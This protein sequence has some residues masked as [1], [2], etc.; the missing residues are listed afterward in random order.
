VKKLVGCLILAAATAASAFAAPKTGADDQRL[1]QIWRHV[2]NRMTDQDDIWFGLGDY[3]AC[4]NLLRYMNSESP[5]D[6]EYAT[7]LGWML[8]NVE[9]Y[10]QAL[11]V[12]VR[13]RKDNTGMPDAPF[14]EANF[15]FSRKAYAKVPPLLE[16]SIVQKPHPNSYRLLAHSYEKLG[17]LPDALKVW[18]Q[19]VSDHP[20]DGAA[21]VNL[22]KTEDRISSQKASR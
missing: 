4:I 5:T 9:N 11:V 17:L 20:E 22:K 7:N 14:P 3:L 12:Y 15:Y 6:Y 13:Y 16:G 21:K 19:L 2:E 1:Q 18:K 8:E 10:D